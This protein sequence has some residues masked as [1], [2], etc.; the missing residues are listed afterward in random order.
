MLVL[1]TTNDVS[2]QLGHSTEEIVIKVSALVGTVFP[3]AI[4]S[5]RLELSAKG[6]IL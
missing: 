2:T 6:S 5:V 1:G 4:E 3:K